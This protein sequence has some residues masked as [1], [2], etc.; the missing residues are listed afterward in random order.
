MAPDIVKD[1]Y[2]TIKTRGPHA[3]KNLILSLRQSEHENIADILEGKTSANNT[4]YI[5]LLFII[6]FSLMLNIL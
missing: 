3:F 5:L 2:L 1:I 4:R 6:N